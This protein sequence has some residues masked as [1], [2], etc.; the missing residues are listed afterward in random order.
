MDLMT[1]GIDLQAHNCDRF[2]DLPVMVPA[3]LV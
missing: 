3:A 1:A 2:S